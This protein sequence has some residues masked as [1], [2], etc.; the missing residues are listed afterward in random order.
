MSK[1]SQARAILCASDG[2]EIPK[3]FSGISFSVPTR[4]ILWYNFFFYFR[5]T[6]L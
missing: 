3:H 1:L 2:F 4:I 5:E 6:R